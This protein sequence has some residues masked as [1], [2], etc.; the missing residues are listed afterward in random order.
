MSTVGP[1]AS[2][3]ALEPPDYAHVAETVRSTLA[4]KATLAALTP[5]AGDASN[6]RYFRVHLAGGRVPSAI[7]MQLAEPEAFKASEEA[8]SG[9]A[10]ASTE[11]PFLN[12][13]RHLDPA[14][15]PVPSLYHYD[16]T[17]GLLY[18]EDFGDLTLAEAAQK[19]S[20]A[21]RAELYREAI[22]ILVDIHVRASANSDDGCLAFGRSFDG[23][24]LM[25]EFDHFVEYGIMARQGKP[26]R[27][28]DRAAIRA[29]AQTIC[30]VM[31][32]QPR[33][34]THRDYHSR[35]LMVRAQP[36][37]GRRLGVIDFQ[38]ALMGP[39]AYDLA[40]L[41]RDAYLA[42]EEELVDELVARYLDGVAAYGLEPSDRKAFRQ[43][44]DF[45]SVQRNLKAAGRFVYIDRV[46]GNPKFLADIP[47]VLGYV[48]RN[49]ARYPEL[50]VLRKHLT[51]YV[52]ELQ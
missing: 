47:R 25:W 36:V 45:T 21:E 1:T 24:L 52:P 50:S 42:L 39:A 22:D 44:F 6:R 18:L 35:N 15:T 20:A 38:D 10:P 49:L 12:V 17:A 48:K 41:L 30:N 51:P 27:E 9:A 28:E 32:A 33:V 29:E 11:L 31:T 37:K 4:L 34:F 7:L 2:V 13:L 26:M 23:P 3:S 46:K 8:V 16:V 5:L 14:G 40:S 19:G 43:V